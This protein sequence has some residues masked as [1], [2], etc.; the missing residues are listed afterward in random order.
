MYN[1]CIFLIGEHAANKN[2]DREKIKQEK[3][4]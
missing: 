2:K 1:Y 3:Q 4:S